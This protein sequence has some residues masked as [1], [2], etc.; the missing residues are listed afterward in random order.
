M[1]F[2]STYECKVSTSFCCICGA[3]FSI[4]CKFPQTFQQMVAL[5]R[6]WR[7]IEGEE[8]ENHLTKL[9]EEPIE[10]VH[11]YKCIPDCVLHTSLCHHTEGGLLMGKGRWKVG[12]GES[13][14]FDHDL[15]CSL[16][17]FFTCIFPAPLCKKRRH[18]RTWVGGNT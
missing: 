17:K 15:G 4:T 5:G 16:G 7:W 12:E 14:G 2:L 13:A 10:L 1:L 18:K 3:K 8:M 6:W 11:K 9:M